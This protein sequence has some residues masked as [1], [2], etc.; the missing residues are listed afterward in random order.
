LT[1]TEREEADVEQI[2]RFSEDER[3]RKC[4]PR[5][6]LEDVRPGRE[7]RGGVTQ[8]GSYTND[9]GQVFSLTAAAPSDD[10]AALD[11]FIAKLRVAFRAAP[12]SQMPAETRR[13]VDDVE[14]PEDPLA[15]LLR[16]VVALAEQEST[17]TNQPPGRAIAVDVELKEAEGF[18]RGE[19]VW[20]EGWIDPPL[21]RGAV[22]GWVGP[23]R[24]GIDCTRG[25][26]R[27]DRGP[28]GP[29]HRREVD[30]WCE[31]AADGTVRVI[32]EANANYYLGDSD[33]EKRY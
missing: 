25:Q 32:G 28:W 20:I 21:G 26:V 13:Y 8:V 1:G 19:S 14:R 7:V 16:E 3:R 22:D 27:I 2:A 12:R 17:L 29:V 9:S 15:E 23:G 31:L 6:P 24:F 11:E 30:P 18:E 10:G 4:P 5:K 33:W